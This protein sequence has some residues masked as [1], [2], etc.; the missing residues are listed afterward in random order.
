MV[1][2]VRAWS[3]IMLRRCAGAG[4]KPDPAL[5]PIAERRGHSTVGICVQAGCA[6]SSSFSSAVMAARSSIDAAK[7]AGISETTAHRRLREPAIR[8]AVDAARAEIV[9]R[10]VATLS[11]AAIEAAETL[12]GL[13]SSDMD[14]ARLAAARAILELGVKLREQHELS[15]RVAAVEAALSKPKEGQP[16]QPRMA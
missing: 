3:S 1:C 13:L 14:F 16:W 15:E 4:P 2:C 6:T 12:R 5:L 7:Q 8:Q 9:S 10:A 11:A